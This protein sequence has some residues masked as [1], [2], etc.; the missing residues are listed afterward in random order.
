MIF[1]RLKTNRYFSLLLLAYFTASILF[2]TVHSFAH[3]FS[4]INFSQKVVLLNNQQ[5]H[6][7]DDVSKC[8]LCTLFALQNQ[9]FIFAISTFLALI[10]Y[11]SANFLIS[12]KIKLSYLCSSTQV[13]APPALGF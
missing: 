8:D 13:R 12:D 6:Q 2:L 9:F 11:L 1:N 7:N 4:Q 5:N 3:Q 10:F